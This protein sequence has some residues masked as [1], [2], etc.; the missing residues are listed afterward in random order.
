MSRDVDSLDG[1]VDAVPDVLYAF[2]RDGSFLWGNRRLR[3]VTG[4]SE[5]ELGGLGPLDFVPQEDELTVLS[6]ID[7]VVSNGS[8]ER[9]ESRLVTKA[10]T[11]VPYEFTGGPLMDDGTVVGVAGVGRDV[12][13]QDRRDRRA[14]RERALLDLSRS[15]DAALVTATTRAGVERAVCERLAS[16]GPYR[17]AAFWARRGDEGGFERTAAAGDAVP[18]VDSPGPGGRSG[19]ATRAIEDGTVV[20]FPGDGTGRA[21]A[22][23]DGG[24]DAVAVVPVTVDERAL[25]VLAITAARGRSF[26]ER[27]RE[28]L[29]DMGT[30]TAGAVRAAITRQLLYTDV[31]TEIEIETTDESAAFVALSRATGGRFELE[32]AIGFD[33]LV[34]YERV[35]DTSLDPVREFAERDDRFAHAECLNSDGDA[36][37]MEFRLADAEGTLTSI[38]N[39]HGARTV[40]AVAEA[41]TATL[42][43]ELPPD[44]DPRRVLDAVRERFPAIELVAIRESERSDAIGAALGPRIDEALTAKQRGALE[45]AFGAGYFEWPARASSAEEIAVTLDI[46]PQTFH[47]HLRIAQRKLLEIVLEDDCPA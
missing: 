19:P 16:A 37:E 26:P 39:H 7:R 45:A 12:S 2:D 30:R 17:G 14:A 42:T 29:A 15:I 3:T 13:G 46:A 27:E 23:G 8:T 44:Q 34:V 10:G 11:A 41:G 25:G 47:Q 24:P 38:F 9:L 1:I 31:V 6:L 21:D 28:V 33:D 43:V 20:S 35:T 18:T 40:A 5:A 36:H 22:G 4:Y 32:Q